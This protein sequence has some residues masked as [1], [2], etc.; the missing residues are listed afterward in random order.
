MHNFRANLL[1]RLTDEGWRVVA[2]GADLDDYESRLRAEGFDF[3]SAPVP[4]KGVSP[5]GDVALFWSFLCTFRQVR[6]RVAHMFTIKPVIYGTL[7]AALAGVPLR[8]CTI[9]GLG[10][11]F[12]GDRGLVNL[13]ARLLYRAALS[14]AHVVFFQNEDD[15]DLF[16]TGG[17]VAESKVRMVP[18]SGVDLERFQPRASAR[19]QGPTRFLMVSR[20]LRDKGVMDFVEAAERLTAVGVQAEF[21]L[22]GAVDTRN[23]SGLITAEIA[24]LKA[25]PVKWVGA[26][27]DVRPELADA[28][29]MVLPSYRE[30]TP[31]VLLEGMAMAKPIITTDAPGC[32]QLVNP[33]VNGFLIPVR[34]PAALAQAMGWFLED[35]VRR[36]SMGKA[37]RRFV[38]L[39]YSED[40]VLDR[41][42]ASYGSETLQPA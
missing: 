11:A 20:L 35:P 38:E 27:H 7:A 15:R 37:A 21:H 19:I 41:F 42:L 10:H 18:G 39:H 1:R 14:Q 34:D 17:L 2:L 12:S 36:E 26:L 33:G 30:G 40:V 24:R 3:R 31:R 9:T 6:P 29:V 4:M 16:V 28:D 22:A 13:L 8:I 23:P 32:R 5:L 25:S